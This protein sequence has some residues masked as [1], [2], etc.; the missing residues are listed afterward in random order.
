MATNTTNYNLAKPDLT[1]FADIRVLNGNMDI[2]DEQL[3][4]LKDEIDK[5]K[6]A[7]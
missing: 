4:L 6:G 5:L 2:I 1:D 7:N 3:K